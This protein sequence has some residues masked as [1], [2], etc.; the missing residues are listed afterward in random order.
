M[1]KSGK[2]KIIVKTNAKKTQLLGWDK[3]KKAL[4]VSIA[5]PAQDNKANLALVKFFSKL[6]GNKVRIAS[7][8]KSK[9]KVLLIL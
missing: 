1:I 4:K 6:T 7:G 3:S 9:E 8:I 2:L 5:A